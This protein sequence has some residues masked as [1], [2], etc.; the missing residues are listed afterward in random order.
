MNDEK[1]S[2]IAYRLDKAKDTLESANILL[3][4]EKMF[5]AVNRIYYAVFYS[6]S[7]LLLTKE[8]S[9]SRHTG[10][11]SLFNREF[12]NKGVVDKKFG[13]FFSEIYR[14]RHKGDY[15]DFVVFE[16]ADV[17]DWLRKAEEFINEI[18]GLI[19]LEE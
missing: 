15:K 11:I 12:V 4:E 14:Y 13:R 5:S 16:K 10:V 1:K 7:A 9:S 2:L 3:R 8:L 17:E 18:T 19:G 6:V